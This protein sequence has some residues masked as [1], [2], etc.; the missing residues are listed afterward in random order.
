MIEY[1]WSRSVISVKTRNYQSGSLCH[2]DDRVGVRHVAHDEGDVL[3][4]AL[5]AGGFRC[6]AQDI[7][8]LGLTTT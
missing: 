6:G 3:L 7:F 1:L 2:L 5:D 8:Q 4:Q